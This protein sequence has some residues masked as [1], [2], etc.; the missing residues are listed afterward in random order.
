MVVSTSNAIPLT[1]LTI[2]VT[3]NGGTITFTSPA[4]EINVHDC[5]PLVIFSPLQPAYKVQFEDGPLTIPAA[6][7]SSSAECPVSAYSLSPAT[8]GI[9]IDSSGTITVDNTNEIPATSLARRVTVG[10]QLISSP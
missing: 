8:S 3:L 9:D 6:V 2:S 1:S 10:S 7:S 5:L 4:L